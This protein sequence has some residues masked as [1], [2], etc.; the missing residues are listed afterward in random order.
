M[1][2]IG[3]NDIGNWNNGI[4]GWE[5]HMWMHD[6]PDITARDVDKYPTDCYLTDRPLVMVL[7]NPEQVVGVGAKIWPVDIGK[8]GGVR[9]ERKNRGRPAFD[10]GG[11]IVSITGHALVWE[12]IG[13]SAS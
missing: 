12:A 6:P 2:T 4:D 10:V 7:Q 1:N 5:R 13:I 9:S 11:Q 3:K 8:D